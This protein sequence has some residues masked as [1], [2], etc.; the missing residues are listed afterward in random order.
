[1]SLHVVNFSKRSFQCVVTF[2]RWRLE[3]AQKSGASR[4]LANGMKSNEQA[5]DQACWRLKPWTWLWFWCR[6][7]ACHDWENQTVL[8]GH[9][10]I[11]WKIERSHWKACFHFSLTLIV[12]SQRTKTWRAIWKFWRFFDVFAHRD[13]VFW[14]FQNFS[15]DFQTRHRKTCSCQISCISVRR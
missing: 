10:Y 13:L 1:M 4:P 11:F 7:I 2:A 6:S 8:S 12:S 9:K 3:M 15:K 14:L 5:T